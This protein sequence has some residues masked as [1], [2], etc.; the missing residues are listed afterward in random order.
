MRDL[1][2]FLKQRERGPRPHYPPPIASG[3]LSAGY[4][5]KEAAWPQPANFAEFPKAE[6]HAG[7][8]VCIAT[9]RS[10]KTA[11][12]GMLI[13]S[14]IMFLMYRIR[15]CGPG[16]HKKNPG[17]SRMGEQKPTRASMVSW[18]HHSKAAYRN[19][20]PP[21][22]VHLRTSDQLRA[23]TTNCQ[24]EMLTSEARRA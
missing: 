2:R 17:R 15:G 14:G 18:S 5:S 20:D 3:R 1:S 4:P 23:K 24:A 8:E 10:A 19:I 16:V 12:E 7:V 11:G 6:D 13:L 22:V 21:R 9:P